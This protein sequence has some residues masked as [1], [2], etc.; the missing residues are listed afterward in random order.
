M[1]CLTGPMTTVRRIALIGF[2]LAGRV[3]HAPLIH[4]T[5]GLALSHVVTS[6]PERAGQVRQRY[7]DAQVLGSV[8]E[9]WRVAEQFDAVTVASPNASHVPLATSALR[10]GLGVVVDKPLAATA[11]EGRQVV[12]QAMAAGLFLSVFQNRRWD[13]DF[14]TVRRLIGDGSLGRVHRFESRYERWR[15]QV[16]S[17]RW[18]ESA[19]P[20]Q[21]GG[22]LY[23]LG[24]HLVDQALVANGPADSVY[25]EVASR[26]DG[27]QVDDDVFV[28]I[29]HTSGTTSH[30]W[31]S[32]LAAQPGPRFRVLGDR[33]AY[34]SWGLDPQ[35]DQLR[36]GGT[37]DDE[38]FGAYPEQ[39]WGRL[40]AGDQVEPVP[41]TPG[42]YADF[43]LGV[44]SALNGITPAPVDP[45]GAVA[46]LAVLEAARESA[47]T[48]A[49]VAIPQ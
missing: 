42:A 29:T 46:A 26:R 6:S 21:A 47:R 41:T 40:G 2:G 23:D 37:P 45:L 28:A 8:E 9:L 22:L 5:P 44:A 11:A 20:A 4:S 14:L 18:R 36:D 19:D 39:A 12:D 34:V 3:F 48:G 15:P 33:S 43:Y 13:G 16:D 49:V 32:A 27:A 10:H 25:A 35:E 38:E 17:T 31:S 1:S 7:P 30:L 24:S